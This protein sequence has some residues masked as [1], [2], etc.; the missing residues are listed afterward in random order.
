MNIMEILFNFTTDDIENMLNTADE[1]SNLEDEDFKKIYNELKNKEKTLEGKSIKN[2]KHK[3]ERTNNRDD[4]VAEFLTVPFDSL[5]MLYTNY[6][7]LQT[8]KEDVD[9]LHDDEHIEINEVYELNPKQISKFDN[10]IEQYYQNQIIDNVKPNMQ[11]QDENIAANSG[12]LNNSKESITLES[13]LLDK[14]IENIFGFKLTQFDDNKLNY[15][16]STDD[17]IAA[18]NAILNLLEYEKLS[19]NTS[20]ENMIED[21][22]EATKVEDLEDSVIIQKDGLK[23]LKDNEDINKKDSLFDSMLTDALNSNIMSKDELTEDDRYDN[24]LEI[25]SKAYDLERTDF[26]SKLDN[27]IDAKNEIMFEMSKRIDVINQLSNKIFTSLKEDKSEMIVQLKPDILGKIILKVS[28]S[29]DVL[30]AKIITQSQ[31]TKNIIVTQLDELRDTLSRQ[32]YTIGNLDV[33][34]HQDGSQSQLFY[35]NQGDNFRLNSK[36]SNNILSNDEDLIRDKGLYIT[37]NLRQGNVDY[38]A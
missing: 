8:H 9:V 37:S 6:L 20:L 33:D 5:Y 36:T 32:G 7:L 11:K 16:E 27:I 10:I 21:D 23:L 38:F 22:T 24:I 31:E 12:A 25:N 14:N 19:E 18:H 13:D 28:L 35:S 1:K 34:I 26:E 30:S 17:L 4:Y 3:I 29:D 2:C 15:I